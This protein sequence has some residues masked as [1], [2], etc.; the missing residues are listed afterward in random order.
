MGSGADG[1]LVV[2]LGGLEARLPPRR[3]VVRVTQEIEHDVDR[4]L[5]EPPIAESVHVA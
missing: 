4:A 5:D 2:G 3:V 1:D